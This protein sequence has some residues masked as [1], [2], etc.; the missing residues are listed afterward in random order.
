M[1]ATLA[2][3]STRPS[4]DELVADFCDAVDRGLAVDRQAWIDRYPEFAGEL[5]GFFADHDLLI[6]LV[7]PF[8]EAIEA[9]GSATP[10]EFGAT[11]A[12][13]Q[14]ANAPERSTEPASSP[15]PATIGEYELIRRLGRGAMGDVYEARQVRLN[16]VVAL[17]MIRAGLLATVEEVQRFR[18]E[19]EAVALLDHP[20]IVTIYDVGEDQGLHHF[21]M[22]LIRGGS[23]AERIA[24]YA[25]DPRAAASLMIEIAR[26]IQY[27]HQQGILHRDLKPANVLIDENGQPHVG[28]FGLAKRLGAD[29]ELTGTGAIL[30]TPSYMAPEQAEGSKGR[31]TPLTDVYGLGALLYALLTGRG[32]F[33]GDSLLETIEQVRGPHPPAPP[34]QLNPRVGRDLETICLKCLEKDPQ[35]RYAS[36]EHLADD[37]GR[38]LGGEPIRARRIS[39]TARAWMWC[40]R[41]RTVAT[42]LVA[43]S[44]FAGVS[45]WQWLRAEGLRHRAE[46]DALA[47]Q[48][49]Q[50]LTLCSEGE[51]GRGLIKLAE[52]LRKAPSGSDDL[53]QAIRANIIA[54]APHATRLR[55]VL[56]HA[57]QVYVVAY[58]PDGKTIVTVGA[59]HTDGQLSRPM[60]GAAQLWDRETCEPRGPPLTHEHG[61][62]VLG[63]V[64]S[65]DGSTLATFG[66][67]RTARFWRVADGSAL[68]EPL[69]HEGQVHCLA[70]S[71]DGGTVLTGSTDGT[72]RFWDTVSREPRGE[73]LRH[74]NWVTQVGFRPSDGRVALTG[75]LD[76]QVRLW[77]VQTG[78]L[79]S[80]QPRL[81]TKQEDSRPVRVATYGGDGLRIVTNRGEDSSLQEGAQLWDGATGEPIGSNGLNHEGAVLS[82][83]MSADGRFVLTGSEDKTA[84]LWDARKG[85]C[86]VLRH[87]ESVRVVAL[88]PDGTLALTGTDGG[89]AQL[90]DTETG[91]SVGDPMRHLSGDQASPDRR[92]RPNRIEGTIRGLGFHP[93]GQEVATSSE[94]GTVR[95]WSIPT[96]RPAGLP[97]TEADLADQEPRLATSPDGKWV[98]VGYPDGSARVRDAN[99]QIE[100]GANLMHE[101]KEVRAVAWSRDGGRLLSGSIDGTVRVWSAFSR[102]PIGTPMLH[103]GPVRSVAFSP[104][105]RM[106]LTG[107]EDSMVRLW[108]TETSKPIGPTL[109]LDKPAVAVDFGQDGRTL[110]ALDDDGVVRRWAG[111]TVPPGPDERSLLSVELVTG[112]TN[113]TSGSPRALDA[114]SWRRK[115]QRLREREGPPGLN[116]S[117]GTSSGFN[118]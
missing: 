83:A 11:E 95:I 25:K 3:E 104:D 80:E 49:D 77:D 52:T 21:S 74:A 42:F 55:A 98:L 20:R 19:A 60:G 2:S 31:L 100:T 91:R 79:I 76:D 27:A 9:S 64:F 63:A 6:G 108:H 39:P 70:F 61:A 50:A 8:K 66:N 44:L 18:N 33:A 109:A 36:A 82:V 89:T 101:E 24:A 4:F 112:T 105:G 45:T 34:S 22:Q 58:S 54:W 47:G 68:G 30:G 40:R 114:S 78:R 59:E 5:S 73:P 103:G 118:P 92:L 116:S 10:V 72:A 71:P 102:E 37:L 51:V 97:T 53:K 41:N 1:G 113:D 28:D 106:V 23:L 14:T 93:G 46:R 84:R 85:H 65:P 16:R 48:I 12:F 15:Y 115:L 69:R 117:P 57:G 88:S 67:D 13:G 81:H 29:S 38:W 111:P 62:S 90:W 99:T 75:C 107:G 86:W 94:D 87:S 35:R 110:L 7:A 26:A 17:K 43:L 56:E 96:A 32:P